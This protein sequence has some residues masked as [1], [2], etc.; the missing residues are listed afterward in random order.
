MRSRL[1]HAQP[2]ATETVVEE[3]IEDQ[4]EIVG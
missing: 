4:V 1:R 2:A 3:T